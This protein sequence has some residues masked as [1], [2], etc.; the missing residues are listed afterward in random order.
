MTTMLSRTTSDVP[1]AAR[2]DARRTVG[3][4]VRC[5]T[6]CAAL[7]LVGAAGTSLAQPKRFAVNQAVATTSFAFLPVYVAEHM[8]YF[9]EEGVDLV[10]T[11]VQS[12]AAGV[13]AVANNNAQYY[14]STPAA[15]MQAA[16]RGANVRLMAAL[17]QQF[18]GNIVVSKEVA[19]KHRA[20]VESS[21]VFTRLEALRGLRLAAHSPGSAPDQLLR[22]AVRAQNMNPERDVTILPITDT[23]ILAALEQKRIDG[24]S[25]SS[26]LADTAVVKN[27]AKILVSFASGEH[28][29]LAG[30]L[31]IVAVG[32]REWLTKDPEGAAA[33]V[34]AMWRG[35]LLMRSDPAKAK[36]A[37][38]KAFPQTDAAVFDAAFESNRRAFGDSPA[39]TPQMIERVVRF[40]ES[41]GG[42]PMAGKLEDTWT[43]AAVDLAAKTLKR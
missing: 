26:P 10:T 29:Q 40:H 7:A 18:P 11:R 41:T 22:W 17:M 4:A 9:R 27:G 35:M 37:A 5:A 38:R 19:E 33:T 20:I 3:R 2:R 23:S 30:L 12:A 24:F 25:Y 42:Q 31:S 6:L 32:S 43:N 39:F 13:A 34:R 8:G 14:L 28:K 36:E 21:D 1:C 16:L 15:G